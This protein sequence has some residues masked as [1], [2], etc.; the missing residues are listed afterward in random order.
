MNLHG[1]GEARKGSN[2]EVTW[3]LYLM[4]VPSNTWWVSFSHTVAIRWSTRQWLFANDMSLCFLKETSIP[5]TVRGCDMYGLIKSSQSFEVRH[6]HF[7]DEEHEAPET[8]SCP[9]SYSC[10]GEMWDSNSDSG[11]KLLTKQHTQW[12]EAVDTALGVLGFSQCFPL[13][14][15]TWA[16]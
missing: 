4:G 3:I 13:Y 9:G 6:S 15:F 12:R 5:D 2:E 11:P 1:C 8:G 16:S 7:I 10:S 14:Q